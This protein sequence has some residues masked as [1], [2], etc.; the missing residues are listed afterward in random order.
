MV[1]G[2][3]GELSAPAAKDAKGKPMVEAPAA[4]EA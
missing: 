4:E 3:S 1:A 2:G